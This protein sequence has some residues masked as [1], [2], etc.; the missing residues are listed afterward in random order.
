MAVQGI[1][2]D[3]VPWYKCV[4]PLTSE[5]TA[6][7]LAKCL[8]AIWRWSLRV[9]GRDICPPALNIGQ[10]MTRDE[11]Q[12]EVDNSLWFEVYSHTLQRVGE[13][14]HGQRWQ[15]PKGKA[16]EVAVS[17]IVRAFW[18][19]TG[20][21]PATTCTRLVPRAVFRRR[22]RGAVSHAI[23]FLGDMA[24][25]IPTLD[26]WDQFVWPPSAAIPRTATQVEQ[27]GYCH[28]NAVDLSAVMPVMEFSVTDEEG[29]Y[30][31][32]ARALIFEGSILAYDP[33]RDEA[34]WVPTHRVA[35][36][37]SWAEERM[38]VALANFV[39]CAPKRQTASR[40][41]GPTASWSGP[42]TPW[43]RKRVSRCRRRVTSPRRTSPRRWR[44]GGS[45]TLKHHLVTRCAD[46]ARPNRR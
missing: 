44:D 23:T 7:S 5:G 46:G 3:K 36:D 38:A 21:E 37:L 11:V 35:N 18:E 13:A 27:Y 20:M 2:D 29:T 39:P 12:G 33:A 15:W 19:E 14:V 24:V 22:E 30:L 32:V 45:Q 34:E 40:S 26:A 9:Q 10:F 42:M 28:R 43:R 25:H 4:A 41:S 6:L 1:S 8:L 31:C 17:P 16:R